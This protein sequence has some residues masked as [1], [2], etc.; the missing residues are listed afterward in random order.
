LALR[1]DLELTLYSNSSNLSANIDAMSGAWLG[2]NT[3]L[4]VAAYS[5]ATPTIPLNIWTT[6]TLWQYSDSGAVAGFTG[7]VDLDRFNGSDANLL[8]WIG[9]STA[10]APTPAPTPT[11]EPQAVVITISAPKGVAI[12]VNG[13]AIPSA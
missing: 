12:E 8:K 5:V 6:W 7:A 11:P 10:P 9:P 13:V 1:P 4:W 3:S 2:K